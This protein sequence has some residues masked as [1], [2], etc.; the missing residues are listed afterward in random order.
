MSTTPVLKPDLLQGPLEVMIFRTLE[1]RPSHGYA[2]ARAI[3]AASGGELA[4]EEGSLYPALHR[5]EKRGDIVGEWSQTEQKRR[6]KVYR[7]TPKGRKKLIEQT[8][9]WQRLVG[10]VSKVIGPSGGGDGEL[11]G[12]HA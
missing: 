9:A 12:D 5:L 8:S 3:E 6:A 7:L 10:A 1:R 11:A 2:I 4:I